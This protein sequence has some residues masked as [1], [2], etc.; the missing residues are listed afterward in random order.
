MSI[1][2]T[3]LIHPTAVIS[4]EAE[5]A[6]DV[7][8]G[9]YVIIEGPVR[10]GS[11]CVIEAHA[12][13]SGH[14]EIGCD[15]LI[16]HGVVIG[17]A[18]QSRH[19]HGEPTS[20]IIGERN[21]FREFVT[22]HRGTV[23]GGGE[24]VIGSDNMLMV[25]SHLGH[26]VRMGHHCTLVNNALV[27]G[28]CELFDGCILSGNAAVQQRV[29]VGRLAFLGGTGGATKDLP[30]FVIQ[31]GYNCVTGLNLVGMRRAGFSQATI[32]AIR[33]AYK[34]TYKEGLTVNEAMNRVESIHGDIPEV[35]EFVNFIR[36]SVVGISQARDSSRQNWFDS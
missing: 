35:M 11:G 19:Y 36:N 18:P 9:P 28:H 31:Q 15:N 27:A 1:A 16:G 32:T 14:V 29:R 8:I 10:I 3:E 24:T 22:I 20:V 12:G 4:P 25:N 34:L 26:D 6:P 23:E 2:M 13:L 30:P 21:T 5:I 17:K 7:Q 33:Q